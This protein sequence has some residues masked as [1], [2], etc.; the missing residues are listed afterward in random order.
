MKIVQIRSFF[1]SVF[2]PNTDWK[3]NRKNSVF[4]H[5]S[6]LHVFYKSKKMYL[7][8]LIKKIHQ[9]LQCRLYINLVSEM[10]HI[11]GS[12]DQI[13]SR[14][15]YKNNCRRKMLWYPIWW[16][17]TALIK[18]LKYRLVL[19]FLTDENFFGET[20]PHDVWAE[21]FG[22]LGKLSLTLLENYAN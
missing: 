16:A 19:F 4:R 11:K 10:V 22:L 8:Y 6:Q 9:I 3:K 12:S 13:N 14:H 2:S 7:R 20:S 5:F 21:A 18:L 1:W 17:W 15:K